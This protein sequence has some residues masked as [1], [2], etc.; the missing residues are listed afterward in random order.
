MCLPEGPYTPIAEIVAMADEVADEVVDEETDARCTNA[1]TAKWTI[2]PP[3]DAE[4]ESMLKTTQR[5]AIQTPLVMINELATPAVTQDTS[6]RTASTSNVPRIN[7]TKSTKAQHP[8]P[9][10]QQKIAT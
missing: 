3:K 9:L 2:I 10:L 6:S 7:S 5:L 1:H 4:R 8:H